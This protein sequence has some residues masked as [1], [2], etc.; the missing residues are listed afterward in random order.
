M[1]NIYIKKISILLML[2][3]AGMQGFSQMP[4]C[5]GH[6][7]E[8]KFFELPDPHNTGCNFTYTARDYVTLQSGFTYTGDQNASFTAQIDAHSLYEDEYLNTRT[9]FS[10]ALP[11]GTLPGSVDVGPTGAASY[12]I[13]LSLPPGTA[14]M[15]PSLSIAYSSQSGDGMLGRG[16]TIGGFSAITRASTTLIK[17]GFIDGVDFDDNDK[18]A[19]DGQRLIN[20]N[21]GI[22]RTE[23]ETFSI[24]TSE[25]AAGNGPESFKVTTKDGKTL[26]YG[27][28]EDS[29]IE[30]NGKQDILVWALNRVE[31]QNGNFYTITYN[32]EDGEYYP[33]RIE[34]TENTEQ[35]LA[36]YNTVEFYYTKKKDKST[37]YIAGS[38]VNNKV[39]L[40]DIRIFYESNFVRR[41]NFT[42][43]FNSFSRLSE[44]TLF[45]DNDTRLNS[46]KIEWGDESPETEKFVK[47]N[48]IMNQY[49][50]AEYYPG[51]YNG[52]GRTDIFVVI[53]EQDDYQAWY[54]S[55]WKLYTANSTGSY[56]MET[57]SGDFIP[58]NGL[59]NYYH[60]KFIPGDYN[61]DGRDDIF[62]VRRP[63]ESDYCYTGVFLSNGVNSFKRVDFSSYNYTSVNPRFRTG[64]FNGDGKTDWIMVQG[65]STNNVYMYTLNDT[66]T[67]KLHIYH[68]TI[69]IY[70]NT[71]L[72]DFTGDGK[73]DLLAL[74]S[75]ESTLHSFTGTTWEE[76]S[77]FPITKDNC[78]YFGD[79]NSDGKTDILTWKEGVGWK[80]YLLTGD[81]T[82]N[83]E[84]M[85][86]PSLKNKNPITNM[87]SIIFY[88]ADFNGDGKFDIFE[89]YINWLNGIG[90]GYT[91]NVYYNTGSGFEK[92]TKIYGSDENIGFYPSQFR[93]NPDFNG[94]GKHDFFLFKT[95]NGP[96][97]L[98]YFHPNEKKDLVKS[99]TDG[100]NNKTEFEYA[101]LTKTTVYSKNTSANYSY[102]YSNR[103]IPLYVAK[104]V[105]TPDGVGGK[106]ISSYKYK[107]AVIAAR[108]IGF[109]GFEKFTTSNNKNNIVNEQ[110]YGFMESPADYPRL[111]PSESYIKNGNEIISSSTSVYYGKKYIFSSVRSTMLPYLKSSQTKDYLKNITVDTD[112]EYD[113][114]GNI[115]IQTADYNNGEGSVE[116][117]YSEYTTISGCT[118]PSLLGKITVNKKIGDNTAHNVVTDFDYYTNGLV[119]QKTEYYGKPMSVRTEFLYNSFGNATQVKVSGQALESRIT[120]NSYDGKNRFI[121]EQ[122]DPMLYVTKKTYDEVTG[123]VLTETDINGHV[124]KYKYNAFG[125]P[126]ETESPD[127]IKISSSNEWTSDYNANYCTVSTQTGAAPTTTYYDI[128][129]REICKETLGF[130][131][132]SSDNRTILTKTVYNSKGQI[133]YREGAHFVGGSGDITSFVY[134][135][136]GRVTKQTTIIGTTNYTYNGRTTTVTAPDETFSTKTVNTFGKV[137][138]A[139]DN[140]GTLTYEYN[141]QG[142]PVKTTIPGSAT[143]TVTY[144]DYGNRTSLTDPNAGGSTYTYD[145]FG[146]MRTQSTPNGG[147]TMKYDKLGR[148][149]EKGFPV[150]Q[151]IIEYSYDTKDNGKGLIA[152]VSGKGINID[153]NYD[154]LS[155]QISKTETFETEDYTYKTEYDSYSR[156]GKVTYPSDFA[157]TNH[158]DQYGYLTEIRNADGGGLI[159]KPEEYNAL[160]Q[161]KQYLKGNNK[162]TFKT[163][164]T[165]HRPLTVTTNNFQNVTYSFDKETA[166]LLSRTFKNNGTNSFDKTET[167][168]YVDALNRL[169]HINGIEFIKYKT[170][171]TGNID[172]KNDAGTYSYDNSKIHAVTGLINNPLEPYDAE[173]QQI[174]Y[175]SF[176]SVEEITEGEFVMDFTYNLNN[177]RIKTVLK[178]NNTVVKT[179]YFFGS[180][181]KII[182]S[183]GTKDLNFLPGGAVYI[184]NFDGSKEMY[185]TYT[186]YLGSIIAVTNDDAS[187]IHHYSFDAWGRQRNPLDWED[188]EVTFNNIIERGYTGHEHLP[189][190]RIINM[191][192]RLYDPILGRM[193]S[194]DNYVQMP[195]YT[196]NFNRYSYAFNNPLKYTDPSGEFISTILTSIK[197]LFE[198]LGE[199][200]GDFFRT[201]FKGGFDLTLLCNNKNAWSSLWAE[202][203]RKTRQSW[204]E[205]GHQVGN[206]WKIDVGFIQ[207]FKNGSSTLLGAIPGYYSAIWYNMS[208]KVEQVERFEG[209]TVVKLKNGK[210]PGSYA[211]TLGNFIIGDEV[212]TG[213]SGSTMLTLEESVLIHEYGHY[214]QSKA[215]GPISYIVSGINS[216]RHQNEELDSKAWS[217]RDASL[218]GLE[219]FREKDYSTKNYGVNYGPGRGGWT[220]DLNGNRDREKLPWWLCFF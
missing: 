208:N 134:D 71:V 111:L 69:P 104:S 49:E 101:P 151:G 60:A 10:S 147:F 116:T 63:Y 9:P 19:L 142:L 122:T 213:L 189:E 2:I 14:G 46:T 178:Q 206:A 120:V 118:F 210:M 88:V 51:D 74:N 169:T 168:G 20:Y 80:I 105:S 31:D 196:Q 112:Y 211:M 58:Y 13:P 73:A 44:I 99:I 15:A 202:N 160:G 167:F 193:L 201:G 6:N 215:L 141:S 68:T 145:A 11:V 5:E 185:Y 64:D 207:A 137:I 91:L 192:G 183:E 16:W 188:Y 110:Y 93:L 59:T 191:N 48:S 43:G 8:A 61:G 30:A 173:E 34:Y 18:F 55:K 32:E 209:A 203:D 83:Y 79:F 197:G 166:N 4:V 140:G 200:V 115:I 172:F 94:D 72:R 128:L 57:G 21:G 186:D 100:Y 54:N 78:N 37:A 106:T 29:R 22:Y 42:Y 136:L 114:N 170:D 25:G 26:T 156:V 89:G 56:F 190:F 199:N 204:S 109:L 157:Y 3:F 70:E 195:D 66:E 161:I 155:R 81:K 159:W 98:L 62:F 77:D 165:Y 125:Y 217:E 33:L 187:E 218:R 47:K 27:G 130:N 53:K 149:I 146:Q 82:D 158:Y 12:Q 119:K 138:T 127:G 97:N 50:S 107:Q 39:I 148:I 85:T 87:G 117:V 184:K 212:A 139:I 154:H 152:S 41:Y 171:G 23:I 198:A 162:R 180:Y 132:I 121:L 194:T 144:D 123:N 92:E 102:P 108:G 205:F 95:Y 84:E 17:D 181:E 174:D 40:S 164:D 126:I 182:T 28:T 75:S 24:I 90:N 86:P 124:T 143:V 179:K 163:Y 153:Y 1:N 38:E 36:P 65:T 131:N 214:L 7:E 67:D 103:I 177:Q 216:V 175:N 176:N 96:K 135:Y 219:Y 45:E 129:G 35:G 52:D 113:I 76:E 150:G 220:E 133:D